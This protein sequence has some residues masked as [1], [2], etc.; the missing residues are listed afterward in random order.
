M[1]R[2]SVAVGAATLL[3][4][5]AVGGVALAGGTSPQDATI[6]LKDFKIVQ[7]KLQPGQQTLT[8]KNAGKFDHNYVVVYRSAGATKVAIAPLKPGASAEVSVNLKPGAYAVLCNVFN[9]AHV[10]QGMV[11]SFSVGKIDFSTGKWGA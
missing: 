2:K 10:A 3:A 11:K 1:R 7:P 9:G 6:T 8:F 5:L 4:G